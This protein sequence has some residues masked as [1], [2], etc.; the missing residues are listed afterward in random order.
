MDIE[1]LLGTTVPV[2]IGATIVIG[3]GAAFMMG[4][5]IAQGW[6]AWW[7]NVASGALLALASQFLSYV[8]F[9]GAFIVASFV[10]SEAPRFD[11]AFAGY[12]MNAIT[13][14]VIALF[15]YR[16]TKVRKMVSQYPWL[17]ERAGLFRWR[18]RQPG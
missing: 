11:T 15:A 10:S 18:E 12:V 6:G 4:Q 8:L 3:G 14:I 5:A 13:L 7:H 1:Q 17:Y 16:I 2:F 9:D